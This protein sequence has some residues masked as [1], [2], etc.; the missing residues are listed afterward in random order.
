[1]EPPRPAFSRERR[2]GHL[3]RL[4]LGLRHQSS[5]LIHAWQ[6]PTAN[7]PAR[8]RNTCSRRILRCALTICLFMALSCLERLTSIC[9]LRLPSLLRT[10]PASVF[11]IQRRSRSDEKSFLSVVSIPCLGTSMCSR[12]LQARPITPFHSRLTARLVISCRSLP[13][14]LCPT[15]S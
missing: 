3:L 1:M 11:Q 14:T 2:A 5:D 6:L 12:I 9:Y 7:K 8:V 4:F 15:H 13:P 10:P